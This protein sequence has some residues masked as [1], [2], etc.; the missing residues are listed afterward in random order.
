MAGRSGWRLDDGRAPAYVC[1]AGGAGG[2]RHVGERAAG[3]G[4]P[5]A[6]RSD[7]EFGVAVRGQWRVAGEDAVGSGG[8]K[9]RLLELV[10]RGLVL[11]QSRRG[12]VALL[13]ITVFV[14][15]VVWATTLRDHGFA[16][17]SRVPATAAPP[18]YD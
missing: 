5:G 4:V 10:A 12:T 15:G 11:G 2:K 18:T 8:V 6:R 16:A 9:S 17:H 3:R 7:S 1:A 14:G 13:A